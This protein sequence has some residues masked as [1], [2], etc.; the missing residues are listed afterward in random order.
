MTNYERP[1]R[2]DLVGLEVKVEL[3][4]WAAKGPTKGIFN[5]QGEWGLTITAPGGGRHMYR[6]S[7]VKA[8][9]LT[10]RGKRSQRTD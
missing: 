1:D 7:H 6:H 9:K 10:R 3:H 8:V 5:G 2:T 4:P